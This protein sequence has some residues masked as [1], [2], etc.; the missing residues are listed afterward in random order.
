LTPDVS[1]EVSV[2]LL[3]AGCAN[4]YVPDGIKK[5]LF[6]TVDKKW[7]LLAPSKSASRMGMEADVDKGRTPLGKKNKSH[8]VMVSQIRNRYLPHAFLLEDCRFIRKG[9]GKGQRARR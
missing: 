7:F 1:F 8:K 9:N 2:V 4:C 5:K 6:S 3:D